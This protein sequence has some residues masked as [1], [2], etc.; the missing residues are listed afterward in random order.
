M[1]PIK[2]NTRLD[3]ILV[4]LEIG[5]FSLDDAGSRRHR[6]KAKREI[7]ITRTG[8]YTKLHD[9]MCEIAYHTQKF[10]KEKDMDVRWKGGL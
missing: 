8:I 4:T 10:L 2:N 5:D 7:L 9:C 1:K 6:V 3:E